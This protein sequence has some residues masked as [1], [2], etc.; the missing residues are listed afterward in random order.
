MRH[1]E[2]KPYHGRVPGSPSR[3]GRATGTRPSGRQKLVEPELAGTDA[4]DKRVPLRR[5]E[6]EDRTFG[7]LRVPQHVRLVDLCHLYACATA[8]EGASA[9]RVRQPTQVHADLALFVMRNSPYTKQGRAACDAPFTGASAG[10]LTSGGG[11]H[12]GTLLDESHR[13]RLVE[14][15][16]PQT[17]EDGAVAVDPGP[18]LDDLVNNVAL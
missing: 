11:E 4:G 6:P 15:C 12:L 5:S 16:L 10:S 13:G 8:A 18:V 1:V 14:R 7:V 2:Q 9:P 17:V 3:P